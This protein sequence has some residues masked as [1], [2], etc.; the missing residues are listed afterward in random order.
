MTFLIS[1]GYVLCSIFA[2]FGV[3]SIITCCFAL[4]IANC[5]T[6]DI[7]I[8]I[9]PLVICIIFTALCFAGKASLKELKTGNACKC[10]IHHC[11]E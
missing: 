5:G 3:L 1:F 2:V 7:K 11:S 4:L 10:S 9:I 6:S 8:A